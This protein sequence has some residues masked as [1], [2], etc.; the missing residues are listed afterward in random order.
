MRIAFRTDASTEIGLGHAMRCLT[1]AELL[2]GHGGEAL[3]VCRDH[4][5]NMALDITAAGHEVVLLPAREAEAAASVHQLNNPYSAWLGASEETDAGETVN[6]LAPVRPAWLVADHFAIGAVWQKHVASKLM[7]KV[8]VIDGLANRQHDC[9]M[10]L[11]PVFSEHPGRRWKGLVADDCLVFA[12]PRHAIIRP[13]FRKARQAPR[14]SQSNSRRLLIAFGGVDARNG[15]GLAVDAVSNLDPGTTQVD[16]VVGPGCPHLKDIIMRRGDHVHISIHHRPKN[17]PELMAGA[18]LAI[19][20]GGTMMWERCFMGLPSLVLAAGDNERSPAADLQALGAIRY[21]GSL[22]DL[23]PARLHEETRDLL[24]DTAR[25]AS[26]RAA[27][28]RVGV[29]EDMSFIDRLL[30][31]E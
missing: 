27:C 7:T 6:V 12:G 19:G 10:L 22:S 26:M 21:L 4:P 23:T 29:G 5:G 28:T 1:L 3:F 18:D 11:D 8:A 14:P 16:V 15:T 2:C 17:L 25:L 20:N 24:G 30:E 13:G 31:R 9:D